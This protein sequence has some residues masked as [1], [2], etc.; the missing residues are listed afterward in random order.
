M[1]GSGKKWEMSFRRQYFHVKEE[2]DSRQDIY[3]IGVTRDQNRI[4][5]R[6]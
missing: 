5:R 1:S 2:K 3:N 6:V 4:Y